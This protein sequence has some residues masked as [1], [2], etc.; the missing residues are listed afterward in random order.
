MPIRQNMGTMKPNFGLYLGFDL[1]YLPGA[2]SRSLKPHI[3]RL[4]WLPATC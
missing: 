2:V 1:W 4:P 3:E